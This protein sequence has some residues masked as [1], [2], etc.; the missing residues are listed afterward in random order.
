MT[1]LVITISTVSTLLPLSLTVSMNSA[2]FLLLLFLL[3]FTQRI[4]AWTSGR[5]ARPYYYNEQ[6]QHEQQQQQQQQFPFSA[7]PPPPPPPRGGVDFRSDAWQDLTG[8]NLNEFYH[9]HGHR[10][11]TAQCIIAGSARETFSFTTRAPASEI[12]LT[13]GTAAA[14]GQGQASVIHN[15]PWQ[16]HVEFYHG[17]NYAPVSFQVESNEGQA[18][19]AL[20]QHANNHDRF[21]SNRNSNNNN[22]DHQDHYYRRPTSSSS[23]SSS[24]RRPKTTRSLSIRNTAFTPEFPLQ[25]TVTPAGGAL[26]VA[27]TRPTVVSGNRAVRTFAI[28]PAT[29]HMGVTLQGLDYNTPLQ[30]TVQ[31]WGANNR[32]LQNVTIHQPAGGATATSLILDTTSSM[33][34]GGGVVAICNTGPLEYPIQAVV[35][36]FWDAATVG[37]QQHQNMPP[38]GVDAPGPRHGHEYNN[39]DEDFWL[40]QDNPDAWRGAFGHNHQHP[41]DP[42]FDCL[43]QDGFDFL[44]DPVLFNHDFYTPEQQFR[45]F[46]GA[47]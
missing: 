22:D 46:M 8:N 25:A 6:Q 4:Q 47:W 23:S 33:A 5:P 42:F 12:V 24:W 36:P 19:W 15:R 32:V 34:A 28:S 17:P 11:N 26:A 2:I 40:F 13:S 18:F 16:A 37:P 14:I 31:V 38:A 30:A 10:S 35:A 39:L 9:Q 27:G 41:P 45:P 3:S 21:Y 1:S 43:F 7:P 20:V 29:P 44:Q